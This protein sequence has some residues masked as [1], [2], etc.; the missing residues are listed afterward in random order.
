MPEY[1]YYTGTGARKDGKHTLKQFLDIMNKH[2][3]V[4]C[5]RMKASRKAHIQSK[6]CQEYMKLSQKKLMNS[7]KNPKH[8][9]SIQEEQKAAKLMK[10]CEQHKE[11]IMKTESECGIDE[12]LEYTG[13]EHKN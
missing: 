12:Y 10:E 6:S 13:A 2:F 8:T 1:I 11:K 5:K 4:S 7:L 9:I 3:N